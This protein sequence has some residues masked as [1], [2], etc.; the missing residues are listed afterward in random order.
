M[1]IFGPN[2]SA[3]VF[4]FAEPLIVALCCAER[5]NLWMGA[6]DFGITI[7]CRV[8]PVS[9]VRRVDIVADKVTVHKLGT[10]HSRPGCQFVGFLDANNCTYRRSSALAKRPCSP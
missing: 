7:S 9:R 1:S 4:C 2:L 6:A 8:G 5:P 10:G 3:L